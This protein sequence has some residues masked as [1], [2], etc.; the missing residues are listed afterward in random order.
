MR[1]GTLRADTEANAEALNK[2]EEATHRSALGRNLD[3]LLASL[4]EEGWEFVAFTHEVPDN[5]VGMS[6]LLHCRAVF[7]RPVD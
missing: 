5:R 1:M 3:A 2:G 6:E 4:G 7:K